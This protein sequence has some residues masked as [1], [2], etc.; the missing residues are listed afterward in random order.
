MGMYEP[1]WESAEI[2]SKQNCNAGWELVHTTKDRRGADTD[3]LRRSGYVKSS[4][5]MFYNILGKYNVVHKSSR[6][7][8]LRAKRTR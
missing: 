2:N 7:G 6:V 4:M 3:D 1:I 5:T 8:K